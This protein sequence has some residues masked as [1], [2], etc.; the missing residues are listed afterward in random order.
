MPIPAI[1]NDDHIPRYLVT[2]AI[3]IYESVKIKP[4][5]SYNVFQVG[6]SLNFIITRD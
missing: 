3:N 2:S 6:K 4:L 5:S 1:N